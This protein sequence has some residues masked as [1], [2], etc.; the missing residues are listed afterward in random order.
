MFGKTSYH[1]KVIRALDRAL[2]DETRHLRKYYWLG[3]GAAFFGGLLVAIALFT[4]FRDSHSS[5]LWPV[6]LGALGGTLL[7][8]AVYFNTSVQQWPVLKR[9]LNAQAVHEAARSNEL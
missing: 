7:G 3:K 5:V 9:F 8:L 1:T 6:A 2:T 4:A